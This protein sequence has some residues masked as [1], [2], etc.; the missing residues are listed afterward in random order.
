MSNLGYGGAVAMMAAMRSQSAPA[1]ETG[2]WS[3]FGKD[4]LNFVSG[5]LDKALATSAEIAKAKAAAR[6]ARQNAKAVAPA[7]PSGGMSDSTKTLIV[8]GGVA[9]VGIAVL[10][11]LSRRGR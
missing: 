5:S 9:L 1:A 10:G 8:V 2:T 3:A 11:A 7:A 4:A 6:I